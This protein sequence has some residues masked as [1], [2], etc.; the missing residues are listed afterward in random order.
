[1]DDLFA[2]DVGLDCVLLWDQT[3]VYTGEDTAENRGLPSRF[4]VV[5]SERVYIGTLYSRRVKMLQEVPLQP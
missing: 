5:L 4:F 2:L 1:M 3:V